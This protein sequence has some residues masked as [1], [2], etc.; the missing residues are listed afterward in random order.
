MDLKHA[1]AATGDTKS[2]T[3]GPASVRSVVTNT[4]GAQRFASPRA[5]LAG[6][7]PLQPF[8]ANA[9][10]LESGRHA[11]EVLSSMWEA[12]VRFSRL[13][14]LDARLG[15]LGRSVLSRR[16]AQRRSA[17]SLVWQPRPTQSREHRLLRLRQM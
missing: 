4:E 3:Q 15:A 8:L 6:V 16:L 17:V 9:A 7:R 2:V 5:A 12:V 1:K 11:G 13:N 10:V 14:R